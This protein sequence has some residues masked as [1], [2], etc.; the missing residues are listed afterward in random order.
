MAYTSTVAESLCNLAIQAT[1]T[2]KFDLICWQRR[3]NADIEAYLFSTF[4][5]Y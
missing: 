4:P 2:N 3:G 1:K 5:A